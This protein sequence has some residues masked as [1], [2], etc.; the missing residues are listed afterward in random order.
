MDLR[1]APDRPLVTFH[2]P[3]SDLSRR[4]GSVCPRQ[5]VSGPGRPLGQTAAGRGKFAADLQ[6]SGQV[7]HRSVIGMRQ[8]HH[9]CYAR[10]AWPGVGPVCRGDSG[11]AQAWLHR[12]AVPAEGHQLTQAKV[13]CCAPL[14]GG[15]AAA[16][17]VPRLAGM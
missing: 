17:G 3:A 14:A 12:V 13:S 7:H 10:G 2:R 5:A 16:S 1:P 15:H 9:L 8:V 6:F 11:P 4:P